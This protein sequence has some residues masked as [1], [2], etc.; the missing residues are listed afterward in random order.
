VKLP[1]YVKKNGNPKNLTQSQMLACLAKKEILQ[2]DY[3]STQVL[4]S[5]W[6]DQLS[7]FGLTNIPNFVTLSTAATR[8][9]PSH[10]PTQTPKCA[11]GAPQQ[12]SVRLRCGFGSPSAS[13]ISPIMSNI[14]RLLNNTYKI[15]YRT[16]C[17]MTS[18]HDIDGSKFL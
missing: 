16:C 15:G 8:L 11:T 17:P 9:W 14:N 6:S 4:L 7:V 3:R 2:L 10:G 13:I 1:D 5:D 12:D 18:R